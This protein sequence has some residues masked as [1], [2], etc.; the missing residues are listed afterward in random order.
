VIG[1]G[2]ATK[3][4]PAAQLRTWSRATAGARARHDEKV[5]IATSFQHCAQLLLHL[6]GR[7]QRQ[8]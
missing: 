1:I 2:P 3:S 4:G 5:G 8:A 6:F 7:D